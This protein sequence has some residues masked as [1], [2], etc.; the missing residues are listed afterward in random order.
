MDTQQSGTTLIKSF[1]HL[2][3]VYSDALDR[4]VLLDSLREAL[5]VL[6]PKPQ[7]DHDFFKSYRP[8]SLIIVDGKM[9]VKTS[10]SLK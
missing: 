4:K 8:T 9:L 7:K 6:I 10:I 2:L 3:E 5:I 1:C